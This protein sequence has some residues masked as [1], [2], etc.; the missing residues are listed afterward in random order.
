MS[1]RQAESQNFKGT[2]VTIMKQNV[3]GDA[4]EPSAG[5]I[6][7]GMSAETGQ[8]LPWEQVANGRY[9]PRRIRGSCLGRELG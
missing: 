2:G 5:D 1:V 3:P 4:V 9:M 8:P 6:A 7:S